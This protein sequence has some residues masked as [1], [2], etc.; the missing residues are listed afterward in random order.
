MAFQTELS[1]HSQKRHARRPKIQSNRPRRRS[2]FITSVN[3]QQ[4]PH[5]RL[6]ANKGFKIPVTRIQRTLRRP[7]FQPSSRPPLC[8][9]I[10]ILV[11]LATRGSRYQSRESNVRF[12]GLGFQP[13]SRPSLCKPILI[14]I[15]VSLATRGSRFQSRESNVRFVG[16]GF[17]PSSRLSLC[18]SILIL[19]S[20]ATRVSRF[21]SRESN[22][23]FVGLGFSL[24]SRPSLCNSILILVSLA[25]R[26][27]RFQSHSV[28]QCTLRELN[29]NLNFVRAV[30]RATT[31]RP[32]FDEWFHLQRIRCFLTPEA[33]KTP[34]CRSRCCSVLPQ[35]KH[36]PALSGVGHVLVLELV[37]H[38]PPVIFRRSTSKASFR[39]F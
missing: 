6:I 16:L 18:N 12:V 21:Q 25:T 39:L 8:N 2:A 15:L 20:L 27:S 29:T 37:F 5:P 34:Y 28:P 13:S 33:E 9:P 14:L 10:L 35:P 19:V 30:P 36:I 24:H 32:S 23:R 11:S 26:V 17:Q 4:N 22:V 7:W 38:G 1:L 3:W 31:N